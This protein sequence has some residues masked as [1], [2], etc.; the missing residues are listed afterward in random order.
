MVALDNKPGSRSSESCVLYATFVLKFSIFPCFL[1]F[2][3]CHI[4]PILL[5]SFGR[6]NL[7][8]SQSKLFSDFAID[9]LSRFHSIILILLLQYSLFRENFFFPLDLFH[10]A[11]FFYHSHHPLLQHLIFECVRYAISWS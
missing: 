4:I 3:L 9:F 8:R 6:G 2:V 7:L 1:P 5:N 11:N 10:M